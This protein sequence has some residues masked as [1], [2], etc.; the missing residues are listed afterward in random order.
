MKKLNYYWKAERLQKYG[1]QQTAYGFKKLHG[2]INNLIDE[3][4]KAIGNNRNKEFNSTIV[5]LKIL[6]NLALYH[7]R[8]IP[9]AVSYCLFERTNDLSRTKG[10]DCLRKQVR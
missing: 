4:E 3:A 5:D 6:S 8:R 1:L 10:C 9:A 7:S 2:D